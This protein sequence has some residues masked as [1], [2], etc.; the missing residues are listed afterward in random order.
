M[1]ST[2][3]REALMGLLPFCH[4]SLLM[5]GLWRRL[6][7][8]CHFGTA[9]TAAAA[10]GFGYRYRLVGGR[11]VSLLEETAERSVGTKDDHLCEEGSF[12]AH[13]SGS[14]LVEKESFH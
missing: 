8:C 1:C 5:H 11:Q 2:S 6:G 7:W 14:R 4:F 13:S 10:L 9:A 3:F 12:G